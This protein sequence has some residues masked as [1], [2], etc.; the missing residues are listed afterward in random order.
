MSV[1]LDLRPHSA[2]TCRGDGLGIERSSERASSIQEAMAS[3][4]FASASSGVSPA[5]QIRNGREEST[6]LFRGE[7]FNQHRIVKLSHPIVI[8]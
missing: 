2:A 6:A 3:R 1:S 8:L 7:R 4:T 5:R